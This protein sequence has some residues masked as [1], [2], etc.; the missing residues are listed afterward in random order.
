LTARGVTTPTIRVDLLIFVSQRRFKSATMQIQFDD[1]ASRE[2]LLRQRGEE[3]FVDDTRTRE[4]N[5]TLLVVGWM[6]RHHHA[7]PHPLWSHRYRI[8]VVETADQLAFRALLALIWGEMQTRLDERMIKDGVVF[9]SCYTGKA[10]QVGQ[11]GSSAILTVKPEQSVLFRELVHREIAAN[12]C[13]SLAQF[14]SVASVAS[15]AKTA[16]P[17]V[18]MSLRNHGARPDDL[19][20]LAPRVARGAHVI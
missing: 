3:Q 16:E 11:H 18:A 7:A 2:G 20:A 17:V 10:N 15:I 9:S 13:E 19:P 4:A 1:I 6:S 12:G 8:A 5:R 14:C